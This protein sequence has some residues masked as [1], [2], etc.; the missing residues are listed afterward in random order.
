MKAVDFDDCVINAMSSNKTDAYKKS[1]IITNK[2][3]H[4]NAPNMLSFWSQAQA[5]SNTIVKS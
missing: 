4:L 1:S 5:A 2:N 3:V